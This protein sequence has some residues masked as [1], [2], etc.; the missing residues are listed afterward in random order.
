MVNEILSGAKSSDVKLVFDD[1]NK[2]AFIS[3]K[4]ANHSI[5]TIFNLPIEL[6]QKISME[7]SAKDYASFRE[8]CLEI[9]QDIDDFSVLN[10]KL[11]SGSC[12]QEYETNIKNILLNQTVR[13]TMHRYKD[14]AISKVLENVGINELTSSNGGLFMSTVF[15]TRQ[16]KMV[17]ADEIDNPYPYWI[18][19]SFMLF[20]DE[21]SKVVGNSKIIQRKNN[22]FRSW[23]VGIKFT[24]EFICYSQINTVFIALGRAFNKASGAEKL[25]IAIFADE[26]KSFWCKHIPHG[27]VRNDITESAREVAGLFRVASEVRC[28][29]Q[30]NSH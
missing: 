2:H 20:K 6:K 15:S 4:S 3:P 9:S 23:V 29:L 22:P 7:L 25:L 27:L 1:I 21:L 5:I 30:G 17:P 12:P 13:M 14:E 10:S 11:T 8:S 26:F 24:D 16:V 19:K 18:K 28:I